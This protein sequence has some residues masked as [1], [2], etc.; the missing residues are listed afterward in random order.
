MD[1]EGIDLDNAEFRQVLNLVEGTAA[2]VFMTGR[3]GT[4]KSTFLRYITAHTRKKHVVLAPTGIAAVNAGGQTLHSFFHIPLKPLLG[5][6]AEFSERRLKSR[7]KYSR[8]FVKLLREL[9]LIVIDEISM[10]RADVIDF[11]DK[12]LRHFSGR[13]NLP[14]GGKQ[15]LMVGDVYQLEP[16]TTGDARDIL[17]REYPRSFHFFA[18]RVFADTDLVA[19][20]LRKVYRQTDSRFIEIL[21]R[22]RDGS[23]T[24]DDLR[25]INSRVVTG[26]DT[27]DAGSMAMTIATRRDIAD[28]INSERLGAINAPAFTFTAEVSGDFPEQSYPTE[29]EL[30]LKAGAQ[31][32]FIRNDIERRWVNGTLGR[33]VDI[34]DDRLTVALESGDVHTIEPE[35]WSNIHYTFNDKEH[36]VEEEVKG[37][38][39]QYPVRLAWALTIHKS[40]GLTFSRLRVD[41]GQGAF[42]GGQ[43][44]VALSRAT[45]LDGLTLAGPVRAADIY[46]NP[47]VRRFASRFND[48]ASVHKALDIARARELYGIA[49]REFD[50]GHYGRAYDAAAEAIKLHDLTQTPAM[51]RLTVR[52]LY[53]L[54]EA[55]AEAAELRRRL[56]SR[57]AMLATLADEY[58]SMGY[59][60]LDEGWEPQAALA[61]FDKALLIAPG[62]YDATIGRSRA[63]VAAGDTET[64]ADILAEAFA[65]HPDRCEAPF[66]LGSL[67]LSQGDLKRA[68]RYLAKARKADP[69]RPE[70]YLA[71]AEAAEAAGDTAR[72]ERM[73]RQ[74]DRLRRKKT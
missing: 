35:M 27:D 19:V 73:R 7:M 64:A 42:A 10:V 37:T 28:H 2:S 17:R 32:V 69:S 31:V 18:A 21:D 74:A 14:F 47:E 36:T 22:V 24:P 30:V 53:A 8:Q 11:I 63:L 23:P 56:D 5:S 34:A 40:Q 25:T 29:R 20:E 16:V 4:G 43:C 15:L 1:K 60:S 67:Y 45:S 70:I 55:R 9:E 58:T 13:P 44:Y 48:S 62:H 46:V 3:A 72:A 59:T 26:D 71:L 51:R 12:I 41:L 61:N 33:V 68:E 52:K 49:A 54:A 39:T 66:Q 6:D 65:G 57:E 38:F 50:L